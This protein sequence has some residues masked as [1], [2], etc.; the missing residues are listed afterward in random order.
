[1]KIY[2]SNKNNGFILDRKQT[3]EFK[4]LVWN[5]Q[6]CT[7]SNKTY[8]LLD[9]QQV[10]CLLHRRQGSLLVLSK[11]SPRTHQMQ[12]VQISCIG[13]FKL[14]NYPQHNYKMVKTSWSEWHSSKYRH[15]T[16]YMYFKTQDSTKTRTTPSQCQTA[17]WC[18]SF[19]TLPIFFRTS[20]TTTWS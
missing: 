16:N 14:K 2:H 10:R 19:L 3:T 12:T 11:D 17:A 5:Q 7:F 20:V 6:H 18:S 1:M 4:A 9:K 15:N 13:N 8:V